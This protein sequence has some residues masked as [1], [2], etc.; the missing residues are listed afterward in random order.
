MIKTF[1]SHTS[2]DHNFVYWLKTR[3]ERENLGLDIFIYDG[4]VFVGD[5]PQKMIDE[6]KKS[7]IFI[8]ILSNES[9]KKE[10]V[11]NET[12][13]A[14]NNETTNIFPVKYKCE[15]Q[16]I[17][18]DIKIAFSTVDK[19]KGKIYEDFTNENEWEIHYENLRKAILNKIIELDLL[20][21][22]ERDFYLDCGH[23]DLIIERGEP[24]TLEIKIMI[25][26]YLE[27]DEY[28]RY[29]FS[30]LENVIWLKYLK[31]YSFFKSN[32]RP[33]E[34]KDSPGHY[35]IPRWYVLD[36][37]EKISELLKDNNV[38]LI[39]ELLN[40][41]CTVTNLKDEKGQHID[42]Y[43]TWWYF[44]KVLLNIPNNKI[45]LDIVELI[46]IWLDSRFDNTLSGSDIATKMLPKFLNSDDPEDWKKAEKIVD[47]ITSIKWI[48]LSEERA[49]LL[50][51]EYEPKTTLDTYWLLK[52]FKLN[53]RKIGERCS[54][55]II[56]TIADRLKE[57]FRKEYKELGM[58]IDFKE[59]N[60]RI[61]VKHLNEFEYKVA[62]ELVN[63]KNLNKKNQKDKFSKSLDVEIIKLFDFDL[64][65]CKSDESFIEKIKKELLQNK[66]FTDLKEEF[67][68]KL[69]LLYNQTFSDYS[70]IW[71]RTISSG[72]DEIITEVK[73]ALTLILRDII[74]SKIKEDKEDGIII[75]TKFLGEEYK[76][77][78]FKR[79]VI[80][81]IGN[82]WESYKNLLW[83]ILEK[84]A[85]LIF[86]DYYFFP[87]I[88]ELLENNVK[89]FTK[90]E[91]DKI[92]VI[93]EKGPQL[94]LPKKGQDKYIAGWK[95]EWYSA[96]KKDT[97][98]KAL[99]DEQKEIT[100]EEKEISFKKPTVT[101]VGPGLSPLSKEEI[102][103]MQNEELADYINFFKSKDRWKGPTTRGLANALRDT[104]REKPEKFID[105]PN[106]FL[107]VGYLYIDHIFWGIQDAWN[108]KKKI[109]WGK[110]FEFIKKYIDRDS[111]W[112]DEYIVEGDNIPVTHSW[113]T[114]IIGKLIQ[115]GTKDDAWA[116]SEDY[117]DI[118]IKILFLILDREKIKEEEKISN[119]V[120]HAL[121]SYFG[122][123]IT[124]L[125]YLA[126]RIARVQDKKGYKEEIKWDSK[127]KEKYDKALQDEIIES[128][129][130]LGR[131]MPNLF[132]LDKNWVKEKIDS[133]SL[134]ENNYI[135]ESFMDGHLSNRRVYENLYKLMKPNYEIAIDHDFKEKHKMVRLIQ[136]ISVGYLHEYE[137]LD[138]K[139]SLF[140]R[141]LDK[142]DYSQIK[143]VIKFFRMQ[144][145]YIVEIVEEVKSEI[146]SDIIKMKK[147]IIKF[148]E[149]VYENKYKKTQI[150]EIN[151]EDKEIL[152]NL[153]MLIAFIDKINSENI[154]WIKLSASYANV[155]YKSPFLIE[156]LD[157]LKDKDNKGYVGEIFLKMLEYFTPEYDM[158]HVKSI[159]EYLYKNNFKVR[160]N[161][162]S[163]IYGS[164][165]YEFL[166]DLYNKYN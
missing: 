96:V 16:N 146:T 37:L 158:T 68:E 64:R 1:I 35:S 117:F 124:A 49:V 128:Y 36:Y 81:A 157:K 130:L 10:F 7:I 15:D 60:Y 91:K 142:W 104:V 4:S 123:V 159:V 113:V 103:E 20:K 126:L 62:I 40:I 24:T 164:K 34:I 58:D 77:P 14:L 93:I 5:D 102:L 51:K 140:Y 99:Y 26:V 125:I 33:I 9:V 107:N 145:D 147:K 122:K 87:E 98:F 127:I 25:D 18:R 74:L 13:T 121:N 89:K 22:N 105:D 57:I 106:H 120:N 45:P 139:D 86:D 114:G 32:P 156:Y 92:K 148:W 97:Y 163:N 135:W 149:W 132:Y 59:N 144:K 110:L 38:D 61:N 43:L 131:Y 109:N 31:L 72:K 11:I 28:K 44:I 70:D 42:N 95:Q 154:D 55:N 48:P 136:Y 17:P 12:K 118:A 138:S 153:S 133:I 119:F 88:Y 6:V 85:D 100:R 161:K 71:L 75:F 90:D 151:N 134:S 150:E 143:E 54:E 79:L 82:E 160:A 162:I 129:T 108:N 69:K 50:G 141:I 8:P 76:Y 39:N 66:N 19:V 115:D 80:F 65:N 41:I 53:A 21:E 137:T 166:R 2:S 56:F 27:K 47:I 111:F 23:I 84:E 67:D 94:Y 30:K 116:F 165:G 73:E 52:S 29:F 101:S 3:L 152:S 63:K 112:N 155:D 78:I 83:G 46:S